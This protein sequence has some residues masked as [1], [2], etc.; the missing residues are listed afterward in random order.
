MAERRRRQEYM[1]RDGEDWRKHVEFCRINPVKHSL[2]SR[3]RDWPHS[4]FHRDCPARA[5]FQRIGPAMSQ[6]GDSG[7]EGVGTGKWWVD[8]PAYLLLVW[9]LLSKV[10]ALQSVPSEQNAGSY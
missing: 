9:Y 7:N 8:H 1:I 5:E 2:V 3:A 6:K 10:S 4:S